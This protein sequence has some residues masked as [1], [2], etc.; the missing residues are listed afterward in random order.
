MKPRAFHVAK[1]KSNITS[2]LE[3]SGDIR[4]I[5]DA[6]EWIESVSDWVHSRFRIADEDTREIEQ[7]VLKEKHAKIRFV[8]KLLKNNS[9]WRKGFVRCVNIIIRESSALK[10]LSDTGLPTGTGFLSEAF[11]RMVKWF[12]PRRETH[13]DL[14]H[15]FGR[16]FTSKNDLVWMNTMPTE[17]IEEFR[18]MIQSENSV[19]SDLWR[20]FQFQIGDALLLLSADAA[21]LGLTEAVRVR[22]TGDNIRNSAFLVLHKRIE[23]LVEALHHD[24]SLLTKP[25]THCF[26][27][28]DTCWAIV[29]SVFVH[30]EEFGI[31]IN[32]VYRLEKI[33]AELKRMETLISLIAPFKNK[34]ETSLISSFLSELIE[35]NIS[36]RSLK[37]L[38]RL[39]LHQLA[40]KIA[41]RAG[42]SG[43]H[44]ITRNKKEYFQ[45][46]FSAGGG[47]VL[48]AGTTALKFIILS[49]KLPL[50]FEGLFAALNFSGSFILMQIL[51]FTLAT[52]QPSMTAAALASKLHEKGDEVETEE[53][54]KEISQITRSQFIAAVGNIVF[55]IPAVLL[56]N[57]L[58]KQ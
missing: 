10:L 40:R 46:L 3:R 21:A 5:R 2:I 29:A 16:L 30:I 27:E 15:L 43:D 1:T 48:T 24:P 41:E 19:E 18:V 44:Y 31:S 58:Y 4:N 45:M 51:G 25:A 50:F 13:S 11:G 14:A 57:F 49:V 34:L 20:G 36:D 12:I 9:Q 56:F 54:V 17:I 7:N 35:G 8:L 53:F 33:S 52:K 39:N 47:G 42:E 28:I 23:S 38:I 6:E 32:L 55:V 22:S 37:S 26:E